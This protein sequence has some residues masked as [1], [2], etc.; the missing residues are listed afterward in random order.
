[1]PAVAGPALPDVEPETP[2]AAAVQQQSG[3]IVVKTARSFLGTPYVWGG[4]TSRGFD[5]SG[6]VQTVLKLHGFV[7]PR[8]ADVQF[9]QSVKVG[10][11]QLQPGDMVF[12]STYLPG[13]SHCGFYLG[14]GDFIHASSAGKRVMISQMRTGYYRQRFVG[15]G[16]PHGWIA[17]SQG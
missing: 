12:F 14:E 16:R 15:G 1:M 4:M 17:V 8:L 9:A 6:F 13:A 7:V 3:T 10:Y 5:C 11:E 2:P